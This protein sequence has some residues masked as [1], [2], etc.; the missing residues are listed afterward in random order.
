MT[1]PGLTSKIKRSSFPRRRESSQLTNSPT[2]WDN[3]SNTALSAGGTTSHL[4]RLPKD[5]SQVAGYTRRLFDKL[6]SRL[7]G[8]DGLFGVWLKKYL[9]VLFAVLLALVSMQACAR[10]HLHNDSKLQIIAVVAL[11]SEA[12]DTLRLVKQ[13]GPFP[14]PRDGVVFGNHEKRLPQ[15]PRGYYHEY[16]VRTPGARN[17]GARRIVCG[18][19]AECYYSNDHYKTF[20]RIRE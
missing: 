5:A 1:H 3:T 17:R 2:Q 15:Q 14:F 20:R 11:P 9:S 16:T 12:R 18:E 7:R 13:G 6:D 8:N 10:G 4:T 19:P